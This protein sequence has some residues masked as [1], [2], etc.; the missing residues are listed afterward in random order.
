VV[1][2]LPRASGAVPTYRWTI[3]CINSSVGCAGLSYRGARSIAAP[4]STEFMPITQAGMVESRPRVSVVTDLHSN[5]AGR[6]QAHG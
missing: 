5:P 2:S 4:A 6:H 1:T 3:C